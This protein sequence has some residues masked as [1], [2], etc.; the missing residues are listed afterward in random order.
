[1]VLEADN[2]AIGIRR[3]VEDGA[4]IVVSGETAV[5]PSSD[6]HALTMKASARDR[7]T[8]RRRMAGL[9]RLE[10]WN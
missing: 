7:M 10:D 6:E 4:S 9:L 5:V 8:V 3:T 2:S 1:M